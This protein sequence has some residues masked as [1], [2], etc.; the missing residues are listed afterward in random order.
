MS[1][2][3]VVGC[4]GTIANTGSRGGVIR[5]LEEELGRPLQWLVCL[6]HGNELQLLHLFKHLDGATT[7][8][9]GYSGIIG[10]Q[11]QNCENLSLVSYLSI[12]NN[13]PTLPPELFKI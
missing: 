8:P 2:L 1:K 10:K 11:L 12:Y 6:L 5:L 9:R 7:G 4:D 3:S 13:V